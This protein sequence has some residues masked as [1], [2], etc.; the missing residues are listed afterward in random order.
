MKIAIIGSRGYPYVY[1][2]YETF[3]SQLAPR[4]VHKGYH[5][6][7]Y[8]HQSFFPTRPKQVNGVDLVYLPAIETKIL[9]QFTNS[10]LSTIHAIFSNFDVI[11]YVNSANGPFGLL[12]VITGKKTAINVDGIE[13]MR[14]KWKGLGA[15]Y[16]YFSSWLSTKVFD[17][18]IADSK[19]MAEIYKN[20]FAS[21]SVTIAYG[22]NPETSQDSEL[23]RTLGIAARGYYLIVGR[24]IPDNNADVIVKAFE[25]CTSKKKL[26]ILGDVPYKDQY[27]TNVR[28]TQDKR[29]IFPGYIRDPAL[30]KELYCNA[31]AYI[32][33]HEFGGTNPSLLKAMAHGCAII[34]LDTAFNREVL[35]DTEFGIYFTKSVDSIVSTLNEIDSDEELASKM[36]DKSSTRILE[37]YTWEK[38]VNQ[39]E[40]LFVQLTKGR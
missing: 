31:F 33:G 30:L 39:Y 34:A 13:W 1:S 17:V 10:L 35:N 28:S 2:G 23:I 3:V 7:V 16:F 15:R 29:I 27:A 22:E 11:L 8:N 36:R 40:D 38:I 19:R 37:N 20:E 26:V 9:S 18:V 25:I 24:L 21:S 32:H 6:T 14:P 5:V 12:T 4:L